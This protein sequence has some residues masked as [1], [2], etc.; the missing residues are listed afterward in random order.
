MM[1]MLK[2]Q[3][4]RAIIAIRRTPSVKKQA[5]AQKPAN[6]NAK[7]TVANGGSSGAKNNNPTLT[8]PT[9]IS[10]K[11]KFSHSAVEHWNHKDRQ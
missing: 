1:T 9:L 8:S 4:A 10:F 11:R 7:R 6:N 5:N 2:K 3:Q